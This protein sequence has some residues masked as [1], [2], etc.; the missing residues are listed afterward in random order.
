VTIEKRLQEAIDAGEVIKIIYQGGSQPGASREIAPI[1]VT[2][3]KVRA[4]CF[5]SNAVKS[6]FLSKIVLPQDRDE[7][8]AE[9]WEPGKPSIINYNSL[10]ELL[11]Q[12]QEKLDSQGWHINHDDTLISLHGHFKN[13]KPKKGAEVAIHCEEYTYDLVAGTDG[14]MHE[15]NRRKSK[16]PWSVRAKSMDTRTYGTLDPAAKTFLEWS[17]TLSGNAV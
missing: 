10:T 8:T 11:E 2:K 13:G 3:D 5:S 15:E 6:F 9:I 12:T 14:E 1:S 16:R 4:R 17:S 7:T